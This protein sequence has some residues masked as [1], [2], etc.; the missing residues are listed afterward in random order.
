MWPRLTAEDFKVIGHY[1]GYLIVFTGAAML[2]PLAISVFEGTMAITI[3]YIMSIGISLIIGFSLCMLKINSVNLKRKQAV[4]ITALAWMVCSCIA[5]IPLFLS[6]HFLSYSDAMFEAMSGLTTSGFSIA[7]DIEHMSDADMFWR[8]ILHF[9]GGQGVV[10]IALSIGA[11]AKSSSRA[12]LYDAEGRH[13]HVMPEIKQTAQFI[14][15]FSLMVI[16]VGTLVMAI[17][18]MFSGL[19]IKS[20]FFHGICLTIGAYDTAGFSLTSLG[21]TYYHSWAIEIIMMVLML[22]GAISFTLYSRVFKG[23]IRDF[24][25][26]YELRVYLVSIVILVVT[27]TLVVDIGGY[28][29]TTDTLLRK[30]LFT[31]ISASTST[32]S[33]V[34]DPTQI[35]LL[36]SS[37]ALFIVALGMAIGGMSESMSGGIKAIRVGIVAKEI[38]LRVKQVLAPDSAKMVS[39]YEHVGKKPIT[40][41][42]VSSALVICSLFMMSYLIGSIVGMACGYDAMSALFESVSAASNN[43]LSAGLISPDMPSVLQ[44]TYFFQMWFGR[45]EY[46]TVI[47]FIAAVIASLRPVRGRR[48]HD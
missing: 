25:K 41:S 5:A 19:D 10:V 39:T 47:S 8:F 11:F 3:N 2:I 46:L 42:A 9:V 22:M 23:R 24:F 12:T 20:A 43:G 36:M 38:V 32:G 7:L 1:L 33:Q 30:G 35:T 34:I 27:F 48:N 4:S 29:N 28:F 16:A 18:F 21:V 26:D 31:I 15:K 45:L 37:G 40:Q 13:D 14:F 44:I 17:F 6:G